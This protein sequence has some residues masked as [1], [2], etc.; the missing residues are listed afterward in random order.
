VQKLCCRERQT[1]LKKSLWAYNDILFSLHLLHYIDDKEYKQIIRKSLNRGEAYNRLFN[2]VVSVG[3]KKIRGL[4]EEETKVWDHCTRLLTLIMIYYNSHILS[5]VIN[6]RIARGDH[7]SAKLLAKASPMA[8]RH[9]NL[10]GNY[11]YSEE[12]IGLDLSEVV[13]K[14]N[15]ILDDML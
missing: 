4:N 8:S 2:S 5:Q 11:H 9:I 3:N 1:N 6:D 10:S 14:L 15:R 12:G 7:H 13:Q